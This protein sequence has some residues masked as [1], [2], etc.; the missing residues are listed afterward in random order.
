MEVY[1]IDFCHSI[2]L[3]IQNMYKKFQVKLKIRDNIVIIHIDFLQQIVRYIRQILT[4]AN[5]LVMIMIGI[6]TW[7]SVS[8]LH[9]TWE[10]GFLF[11][12]IVMY[13]RRWDARIAIGG[14][15]VGLV[16][17]MIM[18]LLY[19]YGLVEEVWSEKVAVWVYYLLV[20]GVVGQI[21]E[22]FLEKR[23]KNKSV[24]NYV[25]EKYTTKN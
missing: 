8:Y 4:S 15:L 1:I 2:S 22:Y 19:D 3:I 10:S 11:F 18:T 20:I 14:A 9:W 12:A 5:T 6:L 16:S 17:I 7:L 23:L 24:D 21:I 13:V 25:Y